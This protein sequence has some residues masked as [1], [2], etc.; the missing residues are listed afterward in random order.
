[1][2]RDE[3]PGPVPLL[4][5]GDFAF[6]SGSH[7]L[8]RGGEQRHLSPKAQQLL[9]RLLMARP[10]ALSRDELYAALWPD[11]YVSEGNLAGLVNELRKALGDDPRA[12]QYVRTVHGFGY[13]FCGEVTASQSL[14]AAAAVLLCEGQTHL[15][16]QG[17]NTVGRAPGSTVILLHRSVSRRHARIVIDAG[18]ITVED[19]GSKN[20]T[21]VEG[22]AV[23]MQQFS[24]NR[25]I[26]F[27]AV[28]AS[29]ILDSMESTASLKIGAL[30]RLANGDAAGRV[31]RRHE[32]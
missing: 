11:T 7:L 14:A 2:M 28:S 13:A 3:Q 24:G 8:L 6:D 30:K 5:F 21:Y 9:W 23:R 25:I 17:E 22:E 27:G 15:L 32:V 31:A 4:R 26:Q 10:R 12:P 1:M 20:G 19:L 29:L 16:R 18:T